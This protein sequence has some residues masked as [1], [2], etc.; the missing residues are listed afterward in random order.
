MIAFCID[1]SLDTG[2]GHFK[3]CLSIANLYIQNDKKCIFIILNKKDSLKLPKIKNCKINY[4]NSIKNEDKIKEIKVILKKQKISQIVFDTYQLKKEI[5]SEFKNYYTICFNDFFNKNFNADININPSLVSEKYQKFKKNFY[6]GSQ[7]SCIDDDYLKYRTFILNKFDKKYKTKKKEKKVLIYIGTF[8]SSTNIYLKI[9]TILSDN[10]FNKFQFIFVIGSNKLKNNFLQKIK[11][12]KKTN[13]KFYGYVKKLSKILRNCNFAIT[14]SGLINH[15]KLSLGI[16]S[17][18]IILA[19][20]QMHSV[21]F[22]KEKNF[23]RIF[24]LKKFLKINKTKLFKIIDQQK[25]YFYQRMELSDALGSRRVYRLINNKKDLNLTFRKA[26]LGDV[27]LY[28]KWANNHLV[29]K[30]SLTKKN[31]SFETH[32]K[33][34]KKKLSQK[35]N[36]LFVCVD[37]NNL[38]LGQIRYD[39][40]KTDNRY[41]IDISVDEVFRFQGLGN[42]ILKKTLEL[43]KSKQNIINNLYSK[44][45]SS[46]ISSQK[47]F[48][49]NNFKIIKKNDSFILFKYMNLYKY[50]NS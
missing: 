15:E 28:Y 32:Q 35:M 26:N 43:I 25:G 23:I 5:V 48:I 37:E 1:A 6:V 21:K 33:W 50:E 27:L 17:I 36:L 30:N 7:F 44:V 24:E 34:F 38:P 8:S 42:E 4:L 18:S 41:H 9:F 47:I 14:G 40:S 11:S 49:K 45:L 19:A 22:F 3:R 13:M 16:P 31:I 46:N 39:Y 2:F 20:N 10:K 29:R 12:K